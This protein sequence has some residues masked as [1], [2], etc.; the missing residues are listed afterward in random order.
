MILIDWPDNP[1]KVGQS[2][3]PRESAIE[4]NIVPVDSETMP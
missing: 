2:T 1:E 3:D 4:V